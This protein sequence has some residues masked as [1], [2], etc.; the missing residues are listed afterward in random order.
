MPQR[1]DF[2]EY[3][4]LAVRKGPKLAL[5]IGVKYLKV[6]KKAQ[7]AE[8]RF[9]RR[10]E[11]SGM[12]P[13][14]AARLAEMY[15]STTSIRAVMKLVGVPGNVFGNGRKRAGPRHPAIPPHQAPDCL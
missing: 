5:R 11:T 9:R 14:S 8:R 12:D 3:V 7:R 1:E 2:R 15:S 10:L 13:E 4:A 6:K